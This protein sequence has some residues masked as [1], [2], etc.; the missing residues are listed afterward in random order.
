MTVD[1]LKSLAI[2]QP[3]AW[4]VCIGAKDIEN[5]TWVTEYRG[6]LVIQ[7]SAAKQDVNAFV[8]GS[9]G[10]LKTDDMTFGALIGFAELVDVVPLCKSLEDNLWATGPYCWV[11]ANARPL[12]EPI[13]YKGA[14]HLFE[15]PD[16][17]SDNIRQQLT[18]SPKPV[19]WAGKDWRTAVAPDAFETQFYRCQSYGE[20]LKDLASAV[21]AAAEIVRMRPES[22]VGYRLRGLGQRCNGNSAASVADYLEAVRLDPGDPEDQYQL[23]LGYQALGDHPKAVSHWKQAKELDPEVPELE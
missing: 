8:K 7:A 14:L 11:L 10:K 3:W 18:R 12:D 19:D 1:R 17:I 21:R 2:R 9:K 6:P 20:A 13:P 22:P 5:R 4:A 15:L 16:G 23:A